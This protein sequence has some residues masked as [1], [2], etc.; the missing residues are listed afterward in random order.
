[1]VEAATGPSILVLAGEPSGDAHAGAVMRAVARRHPDVEWVG[2]GGPAMK[3]AGAALVAE[4]DRL[5]VM[6][7]AEV[8]P[9]IPWFWRLARRIESLMDERRPDMVLLVDYPGFNMKMARAAHDRGIPVV[10]Y[11]APQIW[12]WKE[13]RAKEL[14]ATARRVAVILPFEEA[15]FARHGV[16]AR[17][18]GHPLL[19][20]EGEIPTR[21][22]FFSR[23]GLDPSRPVLALLPGSRAQELDRHLTPFRDI[24]RRVVEERPDVLPV[25]SRAPWLSAVPFHD[26]GFPTVEDARALLRYSSA[27]LVKSGTSTLEAALEGT[28]FAVAY[29]TSPL[30]AGIARRVMNVDYIALPN[31]VADREVVPEFVQERVTPE[32]VAPVLL[33]LLNELSETRRRQLD[34]LA[35]VRQRLGGGGAAERVADIIDKVLVDE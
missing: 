35:A 7:F 29:R 34:G 23:W 5:A 21:E 30:T 25:F 27:A 33:D 11:I 1:M 2:T 13:G 15:A 6:G 10:Y 3:D 18:V 22:E 14:A 28:P 17:Y 19:D 16:A 26:T 31:L 32:L 24:A 20:R 9:R 12:A 4:L 8:L